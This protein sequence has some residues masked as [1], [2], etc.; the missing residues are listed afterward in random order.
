MAPLNSGREPYSFLECRVVIG[1]QEIR[2][3]QIPIAWQA[4]ARKLRTV[5]KPHPL[6]Q[7]R[8][9]AGEAGPLT[10]PGVRLKGRSA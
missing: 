9:T 3:A 10:V 6:R 1:A 4:R 8:G 5:G 7:A 2:D